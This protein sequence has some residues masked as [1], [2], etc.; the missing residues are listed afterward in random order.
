NMVLGLKSLFAADPVNVY[1][2][3]ANRLKL[4]GL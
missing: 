1:R 2:Q 3:H 4:Q